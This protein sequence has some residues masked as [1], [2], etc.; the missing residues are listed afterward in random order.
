MGEPLAGFG[1]AYDAVPSALATVAAL[2]LCD[3][4]NPPCHEC[5]HEAKN[6]LALVYAYNPKPSG[7]C[8]ACQVIRWHDKGN[9]DTCVFHLGMDR[10]IWAMIHKPV[11]HRRPPWWR[12]ILRKERQQA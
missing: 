1:K 6:I 12:R 7:Y 3:A 11:R 4:G 5:V 8:R 2:S 9:N 10:G